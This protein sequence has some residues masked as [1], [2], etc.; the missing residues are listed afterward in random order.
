MLFIQ[1]SKPFDHQFKMAFK[2]HRNA[3]CGRVTRGFHSFFA[4]GYIHLLVPFSHNS[5][6]VA[7]HPVSNAV[8][9]RPCCIMH[10]LHFF[11]SFTTDG[12]LFCPVKTLL[13]FKFIFLLFCDFASKILTTFIGICRLWL[14]HHETEK[15]YILFRPNTKKISKAKSWMYVYV[16]ICLCMY[17]CI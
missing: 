13:V 7:S 4:Q 12:S 17:I 9:Q 5:L 2:V 6:A 3:H 16:C 14:Y 10:R 1:N 8:W 15:L 11:A